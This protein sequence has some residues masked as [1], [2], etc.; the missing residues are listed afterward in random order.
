MERLFFALF[1][2]QEA[3]EEVRRAQDQIRAQMRHSD[4]RW[5]NPE[6]A[7]ITLHF[8]GDTP[9]E[10]KDDLVALLRESEWPRPFSLSLTEVAGFP[11]KKQPKVIHVGVTNHPNATGVRV[12]I[13]KALAELGFAIEQ[14]PWVPHVTIGRVN[15]QSEVLKPEEI[16]VHP[17]SFLVSSFALVKSSPTPDGSHYEILEIFPL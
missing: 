12:R 13:A 10:A 1:L 14:R 11:N 4:V 2:P 16:A 5:T 6:D 17:L 7:H 15:V 8:L 3:R 9:T